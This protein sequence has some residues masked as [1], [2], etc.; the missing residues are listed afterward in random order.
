[1]RVDK[2]AGKKL[3]EEEQSLRQWWLWLLLAAVFVTVVVANVVAYDEI[4]SK[5]SYLVTTGMLIGALA[6][7]LTLFFL[8]ITRLDTVITEKGIY[9]RWRPVRRSYRFI[10]WA[11][12]ERITVRERLPL[13]LG[14]SYVIGYGWIHQAYGRQGVEMELGGARLWQGTQRLRA[15]LGALENASGGKIQ[16]V[17]MKQKAS[18]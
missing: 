15:F 3:F 8:Y 12:L 11:E 2:P 17:Q 13:K 18:L 14:G 6:P 7:L 10:S 4:R 9:F 16:I 5:G 1:M